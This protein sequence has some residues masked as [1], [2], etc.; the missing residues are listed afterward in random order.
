MEIVFEIDEPMDEQ[1]FCPAIQLN[2][3]KRPLDSEPSSKKKR[4]V[5][6]KFLS[7]SNKIN[8][9]YLPLRRQ[10]VVLDH[11]VKLKWPFFVEIRW[12]RKSLE[13]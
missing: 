8:A 5:I 10:I 3:H 11:E 7:D 4:M 1:F 6:F 13:F 12:K 9:P 2:T